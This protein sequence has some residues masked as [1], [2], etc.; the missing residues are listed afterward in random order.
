MK[1]WTVQPY[2]ASRSSLSPAAIIFTSTST[3]QP[4]AQRRDARARS[5]RGWSRISVLE[6]EVGGGVD[7][8]AHDLPLGRAESRARRPRGR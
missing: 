2:A 1:Q 7:H 8:P 3:G 4:P 5:P 6:L